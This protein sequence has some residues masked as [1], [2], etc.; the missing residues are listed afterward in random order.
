MYSQAQ[1]EY[2]CPWWEH[3]C[4]SK[5]SEGEK[6]APPDFEEQVE[7]YQRFETRQYIVHFSIFISILTMTTLN[8]TLFWHWWQREWL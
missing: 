6:W 7:T 1:F 8:I 3:L 5:S 4:K 2:W